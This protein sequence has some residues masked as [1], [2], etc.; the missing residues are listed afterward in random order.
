MFTLNS[1]QYSNAMCRLDRSFVLGTERGLQI[2]FR[3]AHDKSVICTRQLLLHVIT[4]E[5]Y[6]RPLLLLRHSTCICPY[7]MN[8][9]HGKQ[10]GAAARWLTDLGL[11]TGCQ[12]TQLRRR[13]RSG[14]RR[15][16]E[17]PVKDDI[18][19]MKWRRLHLLPSSFKSLQVTLSVCQGVSGAR[20]NH[21]RINISIPHRLPFVNTKIDRIELFSCT[22]SL[23]TEC[24]IVTRCNGIDVRWQRILDFIANKDM[25][26]THFH[27]PCHVDRPKKCSHCVRLTHSQNQS[28]SKF[29]SV[30]WAKYSDCI[31]TPD[32]L[33]T[34]NVSKNGLETEALDSSPSSVCSGLVSCRSI[35]I[36]SA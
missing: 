6:S 7:I 32:L 17:V 11:L 22:H 12:R 5:S 14:R 31:V 26:D 3:V 13:R 25:S 1:C 29:S 34:G 36:K 9:S 30:K 2:T 8:A 28:H 23:S 4:P 24:R 33:C 20:I 21:H 10:S 16:G 27:F 35:A 18:L 15:K 19:V